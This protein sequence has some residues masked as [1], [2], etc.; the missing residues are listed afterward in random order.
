[1]TVDTT[2][3]TL[4]H[5]TLEIRDVQASMRFY[6]DFLGMKAVSHVPKGCLLW[7]QASWYIVCVENPKAREMPLLNHFGINVGSR[8][9][10]DLWHERAVKEQGQ[11]GISKITTPK[12][13]HNAYQ[14]FLKDQD[15]N[16]WEIQ[17]DG[18]AAFQL[19]KDAG[20][21]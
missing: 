21:A 8:E 13:L 10:V 7:L 9:A 5:G 4:S 11:Y 19:L 17:F 20:A 12:D 16:W 2:P 18:G 14:F 3:V 15:S 1:M 6:R